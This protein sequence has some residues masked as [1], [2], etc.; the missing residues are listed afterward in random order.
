[1]SAVSETWKSDR[2]RLLNMS[3]QILAVLR[4]APDASSPADPETLARRGYEELRTA[5]DQT[6]GGFGRAPKF[7]APHNLL[8]LMRYRA[9]ADE[10]QA[11]AMAEKT[12]SSMARGGIHDQLGGGFSRYSTDQMWLV[13]HFEKMLYDNAL[14]TLAYLEGYRLTGNRFYQRT[15]RQILDYVRRELTGPEGGFYCGQDA[16]SQGV[17]GKYYVF[18]EEEI[19]RVLGNRGDQEKFCRRYGITKEGNFEGSNIPNLIRN[20]DYEQADLEMDALCR[21]LY[22]YRLKRLPLHRDDKILA[23]W[24][25]LMIIACAKAGFLLDDP[26]YLE[27]AGRAQ[28]FVEQ[29]LFDENGRLL[30]RYR[31]GESAFPGN[32]DDY[33]FY[34]LALLTL[35]EVTL[36]AS[37]LELAVNRAGQMV[38]LFWDEER[39]GF[40]FYGSDVPELIDRP[41]ELY[42]G[43]MPSGNS[44]AAHVL[45]ALADLTANRDWRSFSDRQLDFLAAG[46]ADFPSAHSFSLTALMDAGEPGSQL[47]CVSAQNKVPG[48]LYAY[49]REPEH[50]RMSILFKCPDN[51]TRLSRLAPFTREYPVPDQGTCY[52]LCQNHT[53]GLPFTSLSEGMPG[54]RDLNGKENA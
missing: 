17:E 47:V 32:L 13:P 52:Y 49:R 46:I 16:D 24:N 23:S 6:Y 22:E 45:A 3:D 40:Y 36:D 41:K 4:R 44:A 18:S 34:C 12:L 50:G 28:V 20:P 10:P 1:L 26:G 19:G 53:C 9:W 2:K 43:A 37:Y 8:F 48:E 14:L 51:E 35:Y 5:F 29:K 21:R 42:D 15:A 27:M 30:V 11:L 33:A 25:G 7:P 31:Q 39:G 54:P 38:E